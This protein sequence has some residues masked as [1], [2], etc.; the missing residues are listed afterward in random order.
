MKDFLLI[1]GKKEKNL[2]IYSN[3]TRTYNKKEELL[4]QLN[5]I[6]TF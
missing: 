3:Q 5:L 4:N 1:F 6:M 2:N